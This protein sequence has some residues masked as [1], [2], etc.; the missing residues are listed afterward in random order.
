MS[1]RVQ[2]RKAGGTRCI[3]QKGS[4]AG[5]WILTRALG[6]LGEHSQG[7]PTGLEVPPP[8][9][10]ARMPGPSADPALPSPKASGGVLQTCSCLARSHC[11]VSHILDPCHPLA[12]VTPCTKSSGSDLGDVGLRP[13]APVAQDCIRGG[14]AAG[15]WPGP[16]AA[17]RV[18]VPANESGKALR[19]QHLRA[20]RVFPPSSPWVVMPVVSMFCS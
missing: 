17:R 1:V 8:P 6:Y 4:E 7:S 9:G 3:R 5:N 19:V 18:S 15:L 12:E 10:V 13:L 11:C 14:G 16:K 2:G 20:H